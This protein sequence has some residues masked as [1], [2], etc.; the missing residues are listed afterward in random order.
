MAVTTWQ[1]FDAFT[2][3]WV[4]NETGVPTGTEV[5]TIN[6]E[7]VRYVFNYNRTAKS[8]W[9]GL[10]NNTQEQQGLHLGLGTTTDAWQWRPNGKSVDMSKAYSWNVSITA[11]LSGLAAPSIVKIIPG[12]LILGT[13]TTYNA[14]FGTSNPYTI[15]AISDKS[16]I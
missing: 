10:W 7:I 11:D 16:T 12:D 6:G 5:Y 8:G 1:G 2:G 15:W 14:R 9:L 13:S 3:K 4:F